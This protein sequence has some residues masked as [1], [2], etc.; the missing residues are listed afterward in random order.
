M[1]TMA[2][3]I[4]STRPPW[5]AAIISREELSTVLSNRSA[6]FAAMG[7]YVGALVDADAVIQLKRPWSKGHFRKGKA[8]MGLGRF[9]EAREAVMLGAEFEPENQVCVFSSAW[10]SSDL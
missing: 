5:E 4:A 1:Y 6:S 7:D 8:L 10:M 3:N 2:A 9:G